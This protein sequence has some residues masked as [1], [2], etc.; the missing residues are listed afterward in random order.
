MAK[1]ET[2]DTTVD[3][4]AKDFVL[5]QQF[6][7]VATAIEPATPLVATDARDQENAKV[8]NGMHCP[9]PIESRNASQ[10]ALY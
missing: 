8:S 7:Y 4:V 5:G 9:E 10:F 3:A 6:P 1:P 2:S